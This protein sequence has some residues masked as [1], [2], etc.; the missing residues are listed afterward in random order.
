MAKSVAR[1]MWQ[2]LLPARNTY[3]SPLP[4]PSRPSSHVTANVQQSSVSDTAKLSIPSVHPSTWPRCNMSEK[5]A[6]RSQASSGCSA[7]AP[8]LSPHVPL[9]HAHSPCRHRDANCCWR[10]VDVGF[11]NF[12]RDL[13]AARSAL[14]YA[15]LFTN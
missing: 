4:L 11:A 9:S 5:L 8:S 3:P 12:R 13:W 14:I 2:Q 15:K 7:S 10:C 1:Q 6:M